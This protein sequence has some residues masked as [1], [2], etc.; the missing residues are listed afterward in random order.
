MIDLVIK[1]LKKRRCGPTIFLAHLQDPLQEE[2][3]RYFTLKQPFTDMKTSTG[4]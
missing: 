4:T 3:T 1:R 2:V